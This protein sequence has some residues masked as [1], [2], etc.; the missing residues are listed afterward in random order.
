[1]D[2]KTYP[3][4]VVAHQA[5]MQTMRLIEECL[6]ERD[7]AGLCLAEIGI[8]VG[9]T[10]ERIAEF[11]GGNGKL[12]L[13]DFDDK[14]LAVATRLRA[15]GHGNIVALGSSYRYLDSYNWSLARVLRRHPQP[16]YDYVYLDGA[17][18]WAVDALAFCLIDRLLKPGGYIDF[19][20][21]SWSLA[22]SPT[23]NPAVF[24]L[25]AQMYTEEQIQ[26]PQM[27]LVVDLLVRRD[28]RY[29]EILPNKLFRKE[30]A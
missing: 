29:T 30:I 8:H 9:A 21:Y 2:E 7:R 16:I 11:L 28:P 6:G 18:T 4:D 25:T 24:P 13:Y 26:L 14:A 20:D 10:T 27:A 15:Q 12:H 1:M 23:L 19:D 3:D 17:H 22:M 5:N